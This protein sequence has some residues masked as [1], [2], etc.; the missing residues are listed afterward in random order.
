MR[1]LSF[2]PDPGTPQ[3]IMDIL[4]SYWRM[5]Y[6]TAPAEA[7]GGHANPFAELP[8]AG[9]DR[10]SLIVHRAVHHYIVLN[11]YPYNPGHLLIVPYQCLP[12]LADLSPEARAEMME[13]IVFA[14]DLLRRAMHPDGF[15]IGFNFGRAGGAGIV[16]HLHGH[17]VPRWQGDANFL[18]IIGQTR[19]LPQALDQTWLRLRACL[20]A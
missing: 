5:E 18:P 7:D 6:I 11:R 13:L 12:E 1:V 17:V 15:N 19:T 14:Q 4:H 10:A 9:D 8:L 16:Q 2:S 3:A 20:S